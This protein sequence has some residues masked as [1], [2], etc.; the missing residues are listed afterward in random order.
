MNKK[1][2][3]FCISEPSTFCN[4][5]QKVNVPL[6]IAFRATLLQ[7]VVSRLINSSELF[8]ETYLYWYVVISCAER[9]RLKAVLNA[10]KRMMCTKLVVENF[11]C[12]I[13]KAC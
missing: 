2:D 10:I 7:Y 11:F 13:L 12:I 1:L 4:N 5:A 8:A 6:S 9:V 3:E